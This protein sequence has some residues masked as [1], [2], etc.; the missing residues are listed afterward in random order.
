MIKKISP[1]LLLTF[2][3]PLFAF[4]DQDL[5]MSQTF[6]TDPLNFGPL[7]NAQFEPDPYFTGSYS[8]GPPLY[9]PVQGIEVALF[10]EASLVVDFDTFDPNVIGQ[11]INTGQY[12]WGY[13]LLCYDDFAALQADA[14]NL[15]CSRSSN[16]FT[17]GLNNPNT[18]ID[19]LVVD[20]AKYYRV[21]M[22]PKYN[23][24]EFY[25]GQHGGGS[26][27]SAP[28]AQPSGT[29][30]N[31]NSEYTQA[32]LDGSTDSASIPA[33]I[34]FWYSIL[35]LVGLYDTQQYHDNDNFKK[36]F[37][38]I[39]RVPDTIDPQTQYQAF[40][41]G[42][43][44]P[45]GDGLSEVAITRSTCAEIE[46]AE[47]AIT[48]VLGSLQKVF[49]WA[50]VGDVEAHLAELQTVYSQ[51]LATEI[52]LAYF[53][54]SFDPVF[55]SL[56]VS[57][58]DVN[59]IPVYAG[60]DGYDLV[61]DMPLGILGEG[62]EDIPFITLNRNTPSQIFTPEQIT[63]IESWAHLISFAMMFTMF[64]GYYFRKGNLRNYDD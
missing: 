18:F 43:D 16:A 33:P 41:D 56:N 20:P 35:D 23:F 22:F 46:A 47:V 60:I 4:A 9:A 1:I 52:P 50:V 11:E 8:T 27:V 37:N 10:T 39:L 21:M 12:N 7:S 25:L 6:T 38:L 31:L 14:V 34:K 15:T 44:S 59:G 63:E 45:T 42:I 62:Y 19:G 29:N 48:D 58:V 40:I 61:V 17:S 13:T 2:F 24:R 5:N 64:V 57:T 3:L 49:C 51:D 55:D 28:T 53:H 54:R 26:T 36:A 32:V 30:L